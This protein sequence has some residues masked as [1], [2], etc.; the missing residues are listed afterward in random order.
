VSPGL[1]APTG[2]ENALSEKAKWAL[3]LRQLGATLQLLDESNAPPAIGARLDD[4]IQR[5]RNAIEFG[6]QRES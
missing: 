3:A 2:G 1:P 5:L 6:S 4:V